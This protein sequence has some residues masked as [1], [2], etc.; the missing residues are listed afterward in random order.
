MAV[1]VGVKTTNPTVDLDVNGTFMATTII[2]EGSGITGINGG[3]LG[4]ETITASKIPQGELTGGLLSDQLIL[5]G[6]L[7]VNG[8]NSLSALQVRTNASAQVSLI[9]SNRGYVTLSTDAL[10]KP[11]N[12]SKVRWTR[13]WIHDC[14]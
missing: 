14:R 11:V 7:N 1:S 10:I 8:K 3:N 12:I 6:T 9:I 4:D 13:I 5:Q 2:G